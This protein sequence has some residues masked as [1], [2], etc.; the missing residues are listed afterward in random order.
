MLPEESRL[1]H[2]KY[3]T[4]IHYLGEVDIV[5]VIMH[6]HMDIHIGHTIVSAST[7]F[8]MSISI[9]ISLDPPQFRYFVYLSTVRLLRWLMAGPSGSEWACRTDRFVWWRTFASYRHMKTK[10]FRM[11]AFDQAILEPSSTMCSIA[12][13]Y[14]RAGNPIPHGG[15]WNV[16]LGLSHTAGDVQAPRMVASSS[17]FFGACNPTFQAK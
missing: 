2:V 10:I 7:V 14:D 9:S 13:T 15:W 12:W 11:I 17:F 5:T 8:S 16:G 3:T 1:L 6:V 4:S